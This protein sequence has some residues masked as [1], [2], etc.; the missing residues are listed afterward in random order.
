MPAEA[1]IRDQF[2]TERAAAR[3]YARIKVRFPIDAVTLSDTRLVAAHLARARSVLIASLLAEARQMA[4]Y[5]SY[6]ESQVK[7]T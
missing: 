7:E 5:L 3:E 2:E 1:M 4:L 6:L